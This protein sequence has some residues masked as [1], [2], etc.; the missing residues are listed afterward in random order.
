MAKK[1]AKGSKG[2]AKKA[3]K[4]VKM[5]DL[6]AGKASGK[7]KGGA[8]DSFPKISS[9]RLSSPTVSSTSLNF[10]RDTTLK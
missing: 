2:A 1:P 5:K 9:P 3:K 7:V 8:L 10:T 4:P 6:P